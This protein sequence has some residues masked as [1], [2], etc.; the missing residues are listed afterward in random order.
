MRRAPITNICGI[1]PFIKEVVSGSRSTDSD[2]GT[3]IGSS[4]SR[5]VR[6]PHA[7]VSQRAT[8]L[9]PVPR[10]HIRYEIQRVVVH[11]EKHE[12][13]PTMESARPRHGI[14]CRTPAGTTIISEDVIKT[15]KK[16]T[17]KHMVCRE[18]R[19]DLHHS[20]RLRN[21]DGH[22]DFTEEN[23]ERDVS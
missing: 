23:P 19:P 7:Q 21:N 9:L 12:R 2:R 15:D 6:R 4:P 10:L 1:T 22:G 20:Y 16:R 17:P 3:H 18:E 5:P 8:V 13:Y 14:S 11:A